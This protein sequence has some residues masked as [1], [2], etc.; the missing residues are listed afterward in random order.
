MCIPVR[1]TRRRADASWRAKQRG[2]PIKISRS[3][4]S[5]SRKCQY[6]VPSRRDK[7]IH[8][9]F[10]VHLSCLTQSFSLFSL[11]NMT[12]ASQNLFKVHVTIATPSSSSEVLIFLWKKD[13]YGLEASL[14]PFSRFI[15][16]KFSCIGGLQEGINSYFSLLGKMVGFRSRNPGTVYGESIRRSLA[17]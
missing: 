3:M 15:P 14:P 7:C 17:F 11:C 4:I 10:L 2:T 1:K 8:S 12:G 13:F 16:V 9:F 6:W 5:Q